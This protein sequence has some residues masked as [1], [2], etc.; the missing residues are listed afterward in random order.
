MWCFQVVRGNELYIKATCVTPYD[1]Y[2][3]NELEYSIVQ[4]LEVHEEGFVNRRLM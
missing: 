4:S 1:V 3:W 2:F